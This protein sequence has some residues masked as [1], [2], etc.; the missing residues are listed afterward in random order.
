MMRARRR[1]EPMVYFGLTIWALLNLRELRSSLAILVVCRTTMVCLRPHNKVRPKSVVLSLILVFVLVGVLLNATLE[2]SAAVYF[3]SLI[4]ATAVVDDASMRVNPEKFGQETKDNP[5]ENN[6]QESK[7]NTKNGNSWN[8]N[9]Q[10]AN[11]EAGDI[12]RV[13]NSALTDYQRELLTCTGSDSYTLQHRLSVHSMVR[14][15]F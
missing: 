3:K 14:S 7:H 1:N 8:I 13:E 4:T 12:R 9:E 11:V 5:T 15:C 6:T 10:V 2:P